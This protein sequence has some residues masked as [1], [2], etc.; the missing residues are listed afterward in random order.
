M[1]KMLVIVGQQKPLLSDPSLRSVC[2]K[3]GRSAGSDEE[4]FGVIQS[5]SS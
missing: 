3:T 1:I 5:P 4:E 2:R